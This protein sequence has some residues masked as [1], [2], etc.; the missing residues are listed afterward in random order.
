MLRVW[1]HIRGAWRL[2]AAVRCHQ[3]GPRLAHASPYAAAP[4]GDKVDWVG[5]GMGVSRLVDAFRAYG[6]A[7]AQL[8]PLGGKHRM[9]GQWGE[10]PALRS[11]LVSGERCDTGPFG[12]PPYLADVPVPPGT[13]REA[14]LGCTTVRELVAKL[15]RCYCGTLAVEAHHLTSEVETEWMQTQVEAA[16]GLLAAPL[17]EDSRRSALNHVIRAEAFEQVCARTFKATKR[18]GLEGCESLLAGMHAFAETATA[19]GV[20]FVD[21]GMA[22]RGR[23]NVLVNM[24]GKPVP[25]VFSEWA[26]ACAWACVCVRARVRTSGVAVWCAAHTHAVPVQRRFASTGPTWRAAT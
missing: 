11:L 1:P 12:I 13:L 17:D 9:T 14:M 25:A 26:W 7:S 18:F 4:G 6:H 3:A 16:D 24:L 10:S 21:L 20:R 19:G 15:R 5:V 8:D 23:L 22:H 2:R